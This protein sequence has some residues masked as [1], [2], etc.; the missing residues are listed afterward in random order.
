MRQKPRF[1]ACVYGAVAVVVAFSCAENVENTKAACDAV[2]K[3]A[4]KKAFECAPPEE[5]EHREACVSKST[6][7]QCPEVEIRAA[8]EACK[9]QGKKVDLNALEHCETSYKEATCADY[10]QEIRCD[11]SIRC[12]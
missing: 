6:E 9:A 1:R 3:A 12:K 4:C 5:F 11:F 2:L 8:E 7:T 10:H